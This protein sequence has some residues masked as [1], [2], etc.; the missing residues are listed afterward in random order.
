MY[1]N[2]GSK[3]FLSIDKWLTTTAVLILKYSVVFM[4]ARH[5]APHEFNYML[6]TKLLELGFKRS[7]VDLCMYVKKVQGGFVR[8]SVHVDDILLNYADYG[9]HSSWFVSKMEEIYL[10]EVQMR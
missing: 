10:A 5:E 4:V 3:D 6:N 9:G 1:L 2:I 8:A 7:A